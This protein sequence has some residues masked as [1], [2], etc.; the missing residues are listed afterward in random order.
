[1]DG[2]VYRGSA[3]LPGAPELFARLARRGIPYT[4]LTNN[5]TLTPRQYQTK[6]R[7]MG[8]RVPLERLL[9]SA[10][11]T[12]QYLVDTARPGARV[13][14]IGE[15]GLRSALQQ[16][17]LTLTA[18]QPEY[19]VVGLDRALTYRLLSAACQAVSRGATFLGTNPDLVLPTESGYQPGA[20]ALQAA[21]AACT[22][23]QPRIIGKPS[24]TMLEVALR[25]LRVAPDQAVLLGDNLAT[26]IP[27]A[28]ALGVPPVLLLTGVSDGTDL[29]RAK[30]QPDEVYPDLPA[31][32][33]AVAAVET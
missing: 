25:R 17:G 18:D 9:T 33:A 12:A 29:A 1:L 7:H 23:I 13:L 3:V 28:R 14:A 4:L 10:Q 31:L 22:G 8:I 11:A 15:R 26:D 6:L 30:S 20:G 19:V 24:A 32:L 27:A 21:I 2:V 5:S 16:A